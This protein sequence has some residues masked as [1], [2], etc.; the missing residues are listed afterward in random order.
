MFILSMPKL[1]DISD[2][3]TTKDTISQLQREM[4]TIGQR[5]F[6][7][8]SALKILREAVI[9]RYEA[10]G[11][12]EEDCDHPLWTY[13]GLGQTQCECCRK[14]GSYQQQENNG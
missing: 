13:R 9:Q 14:N 7:A 11:I 1:P 4:S 12:T 6:S 5:L 2:Y 10:A 3:L 8:D